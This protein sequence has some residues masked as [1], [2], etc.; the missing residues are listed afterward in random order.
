MRSWSP[1]LALPLLAGCS[2]PAAAPS[3][4]DDLVHFF[5]AQVPDSD[6]ALVLEGMA[7]LEDR[8][9]EQL[10]EAEEGYLSGSVSDLSLDEVVDLD[11][12]LWEPDP[13]RA[14]GAYILG[15]LPCSVEEALEIYLEPDQLALFPD[16]YVGYERTWEGDPVC[17]GTGTCTHAD[18]TSWIEDSLAGFATSYHLLNQFRRVEAEDGALSFIGRAAM[19]EPAQESI[20]AASFEQ[21]YHLEVFAPRP[22]GGSLHLYAN[23]NHGTLTGV[24]DDAPLWSS[25][26]IDGLLEWD[27]WAADF[28]TP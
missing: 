7:H 16:A 2:A 18:W 4:L 20:S 27:G 14:T 15:E 12:L 5:L 1:L 21:S 6:D 11:L 8:Y 22:G 13:L 19:P 25:Q 28:C 23:W 3:D 26:Y 10:D 24:S 17:L 9:L